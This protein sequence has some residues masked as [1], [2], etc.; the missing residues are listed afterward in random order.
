MEPASQPTTP[1]VLSYQTP[2]VGARPLTR[3]DTLIRWMGV[4]LIL[5][6]VLAG[7]GSDRVQIP[8]SK[9]YALSL[10]LILVPTLVWTTIRKVS[11]GGFLFALVLTGFA[12]MSV[13]VMWFWN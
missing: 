1:P 11:G 5:A 2:S 7:V 3:R 6:V 9:K 13:F 10:S 4:V 12:A 8:L